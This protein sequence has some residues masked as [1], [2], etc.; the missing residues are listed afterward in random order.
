MAVQ[1]LVDPITLYKV[2]ASADRQQLPAA[3]NYLLYRLAAILSV[4]ELL[5]L[6]LLLLCLSLINYHLMSVLS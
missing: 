1:G 4:D 5:L 2:S 3:V 6:L